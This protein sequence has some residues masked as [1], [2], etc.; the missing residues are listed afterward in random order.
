MIEFL[1][2]H[3][4]I[5]AQIVGFCAMGVAIIAYQNNKHKNILLLMVLCCTLWCVHFGMLGSWTA[6]AMNAL[7]VVRNIVFCFRGKKKWADSIAVPAVFILL[8][9]IMT[10]VTFKNDWWNIV[11]FIA[12][13]FAVISTWQTDAKMLRYLTIPICILWFSF[14]FSHGSWAGS[15]NEVFAFTSIIVAII[16]YDILKKE[17]KKK[18]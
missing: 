10:V 15:A 3:L 7:N 4:Y 13:I 1:T 5:I 12:S 11:P 14:N 18:A 2:E 6:V 8:S 17:E 16:R 9:L